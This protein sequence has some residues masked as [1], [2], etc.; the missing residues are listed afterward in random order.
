MRKCAT[1]FK[2]N[3]KT[4][5]F[6]TNMSYAQVVARNTEMPDVS[7]NVSLI[8]KPNEKQT[9]EKTKAELNKK[10]KG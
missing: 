7:K 3:S 10:V 4:D 6:E 1:K 9:I 2:K 5:K 8:I